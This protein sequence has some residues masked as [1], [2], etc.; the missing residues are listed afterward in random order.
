MYFTFPMDDSEW[1]VEFLISE[2]EDVMKNGTLEKVQLYLKDNR[3]YYHYITYCAARY[4]RLDVLKWAKANNYTWD[5]WRC[6]GN[7][8]PNI[9][10]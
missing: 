2:W 5:N 6:R 1:E 9:S 3:V 7:D 4:G 10:K 8:Y